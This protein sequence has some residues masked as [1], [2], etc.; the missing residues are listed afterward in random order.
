MSQAARAGIL[1][2]VLLLP[3]AASAIDFPPIEPSPELFRLHRERLLASLP[4]NSV[5]VFRSAPRRTMSHDTTYLY[6]QDSD[7]YYLTGLEEPD[8]VAVLRPAAADGKRY[9]LFV[10]TREKRAEAYEGRRPAPEG[11][12]ARYGAH[13]AFPAEEFLSRMSRYDPA[14]RG[15]SGY[16]A[17]V[18]KLYLSD[19]GDAEWAGKLRS[20]HQEMRSRDAG[21]ATV[22]DA[23]EVVH[24]MRVV[25]DEEE[26]RLIRRATEISGRAHVL[27]M[28]AAAPGRYEFE[29]QAA[30]D[31]YCL[32]NGSRR[33]AYPSIVGSG[34]N[35]IFLHW[36]R[37]DRRMQ[38]GDVLVNDSGAEYASYATDITRTYP[39]SG[40]FS[41]EQRAVY[42]IVLEAQKRAMARVRPGA[43]HDEIGLAAARAQTEG[44]VS[45]GLLSGEVEK[46]LKENAYRRFTVHGISHW[47]GL[48][49]HDVGR[50]MVGSG[51]RTLEPGMVFTV[52]PGIYIPADSPGVDPKW[53]NIGVRIED[54]LLVTKDGY[55][56]LSCSVPREAEEVEK[57]VLSS[58]P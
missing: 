55:E 30:L 40:R 58:R 49:V 12:V 32:G 29:V 26:L 28:K 37:N 13:A 7:F 57:T 11:A 21:P 1:L 10:P 50:Y 3:G 15:Y 25:K 27:A 19:G 41:R 54:V 17:G 43:R 35:S 33:M 39:V 51:S 8:S 34:P 48:D 4:A 22:V 6:R 16:L 14:S 52:E 53:W 42:E 18:D 45:L 2:S 56:C 47:V 9:V 36:S 31:G 23:R 24:E 5:A 20:A 38:E 44:L 46:L